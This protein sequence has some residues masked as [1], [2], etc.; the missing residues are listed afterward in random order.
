[1]TSRDPEGQGRER[2]I[3]LNI[4]KSVGVNG[5]PT[6]PPTGNNVVR[7]EWLRHR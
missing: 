4:S 5:A 3:G 2:D 1:M 7:V 6:H